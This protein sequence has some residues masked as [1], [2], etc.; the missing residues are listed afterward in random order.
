MQDATQ[1]NT[2][3]DKAPKPSGLVPKNLQAFVLVGLALV[4]VL[5]MAITGHKSTAI[6]AALSPAGAKPL[7]RKSKASYGEIILLTP[8]PPML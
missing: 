2:I 1:Q 3:S 4:M 5:I 6:P 7:N 8:T